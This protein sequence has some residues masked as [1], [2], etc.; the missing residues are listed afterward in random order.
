MRCSGLAKLL[1]WNSSLANKPCANVIQGN[2]IQTNRQGNLLSNTAP[3]PHRNSNIVIRWREID[4]IRLVCAQ[5][6]KVKEPLSHARAVLQ[7]FND[8]DGVCVFHWCGS[9]EDSG[10]G[11][12]TV[13]TL[14]IETVDGLVQ[15][16]AADGFGVI[17]VVLTASCW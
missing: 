9:I 1:G 5:V 15:L 7:S 4:G 11:C 16:I 3:E 17:D 10:V 2:I 8:A 13:E 14:G 6:G 12:K